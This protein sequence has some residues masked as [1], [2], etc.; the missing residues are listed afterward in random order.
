M[1]RRASVVVIAMVVSLLLGV[2]A[3]ASSAFVNVPP[4]NPCGGVYQNPD[5]SYSVNLPRSIPVV[6]VYQFY[7]IYMQD[8]FW[9]ISEDEKDQIVE[10]YRTGKDTY[11]YQ[12]I[13]GFVEENSAAWNVPVY[14]FWN[15]ETM[16]HFY[17]A[18]EA[19]K[20]TLARTLKDGT[21][22]YVYE[23]IAWYAPAN[24][25]VPVYRF[26]DRNAFNHYYTSS[27][28]EYQDLSA[29]YLAGTSPFRYEGIGWNWY[30]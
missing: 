22:H 28:D 5:Q 16:D 26:F 2:C 21:D 29:Q 7:S 17:T 1:R 6:P 10:N 9:T 18:S 23:G 27:T 11:Q 14:R 25:G 19:E 30:E 12:G 4:A 15:K 8:Y 13:A 20:D 24:D 3:Q